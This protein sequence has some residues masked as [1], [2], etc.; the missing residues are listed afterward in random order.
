MPLVD[1]VCGKCGE[2]SELLVRLGEDDFVCPACGSKEV[3]KQI[4]APA[5]GRSGSLPVSSASC[6]PS[7]PPCGPGCCRLP[8]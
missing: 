3:E 8:S 6:P 1:V 2:A 4:G 7:L 5:I